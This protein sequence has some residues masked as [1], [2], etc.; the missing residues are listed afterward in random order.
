MSSTERDIADLA[1]RLSAAA[2]RPGARRVL[3]LD[4]DG[5]LAP[6]APTPDQA[7]V[8]TDV[9]GTLRDLQRAGWQLVIASGRRLSELPRLVPLPGALFFG[10]HGLE[11][12]SGDEEPA[13]AESFVRRLGELEQRAR[14]LATGI[15]G[16]RIERKPAGLAI[17]DRL[18]ADRQGWLTVVRAWLGAQDLAGFET[19]RGRRVIELRPA[20]VHKG[21]VVTRVLGKFSQRDESVLAA[22]DDVTDEDL[23]A[24][25]RPIGL[26]VRVGPRRER[27]W[28]EYRLPCPHHLAAVLQA[29]AARASRATRPVTSTSV[30]VSGRGADPA[31]SANEP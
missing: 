14:G 8:P 19:I 9:L 25:V 7:E 17:H 30:G 23:F 22:G 18:V 10:S 15:P 2:A 26:T 29:L 24:A 28:A 13:L 1:A 4:V 11:R 6:I 3:F 5:T 20:G 21:V 16:V 12:S 31:A 27:T